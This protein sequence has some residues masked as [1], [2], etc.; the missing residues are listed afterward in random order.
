MNL[1][2]YVSFAVKIGLIDSCCADFHLEVGKVIGV[3]VAAPFL[4]FHRPSPKAQ[5]WK[6]GVR[7]RP[8][9]C[10][11]RTRPRSRGEHA[12]FLN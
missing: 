8:L 11:P 5:V 6:T 12:R 1:N 2:R 3:V 4:K 10:R 7:G 9:F